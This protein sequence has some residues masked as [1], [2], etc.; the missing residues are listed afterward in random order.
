MSLGD[1]PNVGWKSLRDLDTKGQAYGSQD[2]YSMFS[3]IMRNGIYGQGGIDKMARAQRGSAMF[4]INN[5][6]NYGDRGAAGRLD[7][8]D[9]G[10]YRASLINH[11]F[12]PVVGQT[13]AAIPSWMQQ[14]MASKSSVGGMGLMQ[15]I[16]QMMQRQQG[17]YKNAHDASF[18]EK[19][20]G[21]L[22]L[23][24]GFADMFSGN[25]AAT[26][27]A[28]SAAGAAGYSAGSQVSMDQIMSM[29]K[30]M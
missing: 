18:G 2:L 11:A 13:A 17:G 25:G 1:A 3:D 23:I 16:Q 28:T 21:V 30:G 7:G 14:N 29:L 19:L 26:S 24:P 12:T 9:S 15:L 22:K 27:A 8:T 6:V 10:G 5:A 20:M 4:D